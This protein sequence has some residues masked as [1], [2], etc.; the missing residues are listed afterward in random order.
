MKILTFALFMAPVLLTAQAPAPPQASPERKAAEAAVRERAK[1]FYD[2]LVAGK[3][4]AAEALVCESSKDDYYSM[5]KGHP[6][7][8]E[9]GSV[10]VGDD[11]KSAKAVVLTEEDFPGV[12]ELKRIKMPTP[13]DWKLENGSW[14]YFLDLKE[15]V[16]MTP[17]GLAAN[18][19]GTSKTDLKPGE[20]PKAPKIE[21]EKLVQAVAYSK[22]T[23]ELPRAASGSDEIVITNGLPGPVQYQLGC[24]TLAGLTCKLDREGVTGGGTARL[25]V[26]FAYHGAPIPEGSVVTLW[27][28]PFMSEQRFPILAPGK[29]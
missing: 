25:T 8:A 27:V 18:V 14:C 1:Q 15:S 17:M 2:L 7:G 24:P 22:H 5:N 11:L 23:V 29:K 9:V 3:A 26:K 13:T 28:L 20:A 4:R 21:P 16:F 19:K 12:S 10:F 6:Y